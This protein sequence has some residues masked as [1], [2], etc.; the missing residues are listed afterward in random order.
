MLE[1][2]FYVVN[3]RYNIQLAEDEYGRYLY[4]TAEQ[5]Q[6][7]GPFGAHGVA[8]LIAP[9]AMALLLV[10]WSEQELVHLGLEL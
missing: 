7:V 1:Y 4:L 5:F 2:L 6:V 8:V 10:L 3:N 9:N